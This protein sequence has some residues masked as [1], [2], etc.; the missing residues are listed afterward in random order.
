MDFVVDRNTH[1]QGR[2][3]PG[4]RLPILAPEAL[5]DRQPDYLLLLA[6]NVKNE[7]MAQQAEYAARGGSFIVPVPR[8]VI[9]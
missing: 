3:M 1:K 2:Y 5:L 7:I 4:A 9:L 8:P 6:W